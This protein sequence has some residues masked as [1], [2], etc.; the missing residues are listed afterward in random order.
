MNETNPISPLTVIAIFAG[1]IEASALA[2]LPFLSE[3][4]QTIYTWFLVGFP[5]FLT[6]LFFLTL[7]FNYRSLYSP[8]TQASRLSA[9]ERSE[10]DVP[11]SQTRTLANGSSLPV[12][13]DAQ[14]LVVSGPEARRTVEQHMTQVVNTT[15][16][17]HCHWIIYDRERSLCVR[18]RVEPLPTGQ[19]P[20]ATT[21]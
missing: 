14:T 17:V 13:V 6:L 2:S 9:A 12:D 1:I 10:G 7:N 19:P 15:P 16:P 8:M 11:H 4:S 21:T 5:F 18:L 20:C 3:R